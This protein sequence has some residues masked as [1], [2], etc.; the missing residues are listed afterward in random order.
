MKDSLARTGDVVHLWNF[1]H[2]G[3]PG[4]AFIL[5]VKKGRSV[6]AQPRQGIEHDADAPS[7]RSRT[8]APAPAPTALHI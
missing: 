4:G 2:I 7:F 5:G 8:F 3:P 6:V 1:R